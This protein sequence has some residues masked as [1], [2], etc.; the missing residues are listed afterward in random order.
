MSAPQALG[1]SYR[2][3]SALSIVLHLLALVVLCS[4]WTARGHDFAARETT[5]IERVR[6]SRIEIFSH[7]P[8]TSV[9]AAVTAPS[10]PPVPRL[11]VAR[12]HLPFVKTRNPM[13]KTRLPIRSDAAKPTVTRQIMSHAATTALIADT[14]AKPAATVPADKPVVAQTA[15][16]APVSEQTA[17]PTPVVLAATKITEESADVPSGGWG[18][19]FAKP[20]VADDDALASLRASVHTPDALAAEVTVDDTGRATHVTLPP[21]LASDVRAQIE[22]R[23]LALRYVP[24]ECNGLRCAATLRIAL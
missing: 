18:Q 2:R 8:R 4:M 12:I 22:Q 13:T 7:R 5:A 3:A 9:A 6:I 19:S 17:M 16:P 10:R 11:V 23:L 21:S 14:H 24:A 1:I 15:A 20:I